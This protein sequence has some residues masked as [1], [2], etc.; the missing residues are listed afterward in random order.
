MKTSTA[1]MLVLV[2]VVAPARAEDD[3]KAAALRGEIEVSELERDVDKDLLREALLLAGR[4]GM[5]QAA[6]RPES[7]EARKRDQA[8]L[9]ALQEYIQVK[10]LAVVKRT[11]ELR[12]KASES[13]ALEK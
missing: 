11:A 6:D 3:D 13:S 2:L 1:F 10:R 9:L 12:R 7:D 4:A 8:D 5:G